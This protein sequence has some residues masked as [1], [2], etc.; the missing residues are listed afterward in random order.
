SQTRPAIA[1]AEWGRLLPRVF[2]GGRLSGNSRRFAQPLWRYEHGARLTAL[3]GEYHIE[4][5]VSGDTVTDVLEDVS[6]SREDLL[7][8]LRR[9]IDCVLRPRRL[10]LEESRQLLKIYETGLASYT[11]LEGD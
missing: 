10:T 3:N 2:S 6:Y 4:A 7:A 9:S 11:Y 8:R 1:C 5:V